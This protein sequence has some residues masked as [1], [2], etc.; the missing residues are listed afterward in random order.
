MKII[1]SINE[2]IIKLLELK[3]DVNT[4]ILLGKSNIEHMKN[5]H[6]ADYDKYKDEI[7]NILSNPDYIGSNPTD[8]SIEY[9]KEYFVDNEYVKV[10]VRVSSQN[11]YYA[12]TLY[13]LNSKRVINY[14]A[15]GTLK[16]IK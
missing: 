8:G 3:I 7:E 5:K 2:N 4:P 12:R 16:P 9:V 10:A 6:P 14:I 13:I 1:G 11:K 15:K